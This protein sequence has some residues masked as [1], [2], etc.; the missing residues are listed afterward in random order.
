MDSKEIARMVVA[1]YNTGL[2]DG[3]GQKERLIF[4]PD[5]ALVRPSSNA[6]I[7]S[8]EMYG[9]K[10]YTGIVRSTILGSGCNVYYLDGF[11]YGND[12]MRDFL[13]NNVEVTIRRVSSK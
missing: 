4:V 12:W 8:M 11:T 10:I 7:K 2:E 1:A 13:T 6:Q 9:T 5:D 3:Q